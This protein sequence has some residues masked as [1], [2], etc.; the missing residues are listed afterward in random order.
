MKSHDRVLKCSFSDCD[1][2]H[3]CFSSQSLLDQHLSETH[4]NRDSVPTKSSH[5]EPYHPQDLRS[6]FLDAI[7]AEELICARKLLE[8]IPNPPL[9]KAM[10]NAIRTSSVPAVRLL[11]EFGYTD[12]IN[13]PDENL[14][15]VIQSKE[16]EILRVFLEHGANPKTF[17]GIP[18]YDADKNQGP[19]DLAFTAKSPES[20]K[21]LMNYGAD[22]KLRTWNLRGMHGWKEMGPEEELV[23]IQCIQILLEHT[24]SESAESELLLAISEGCK[25]IEI[26]RYLLENG[27][28]INFICVRKEVPYLKIGSTAIY[29][30]T[31][32]ANKRSAEFLRFLLQSGADP[33]IKSGK[34]AG[35]RP[36]ARNVSKYLG[37]TWDELCQSTSSSRRTINPAVT[38]GVPAQSN[39]A[40]RSADYDRPVSGD[41]P[42]RPL[43]PFSIDSGNQSQQERP[44]GQEESSTSKRRRLA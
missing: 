43:E 3:I 40:V 4:Q 21:L 41:L 22:I 17:P 34:L 29:L 19:V 12:Y 30:A 24:A 16:V 28:N 10:E 9:S 31:R 14:H 37:M 2:A 20:M 26:A 44:L 39:I 15:L 5:N 13:T 42:L 32:H 38:S 1:L 33:T 7:E 25:S 11:L 35:E 8:R 36:G 6:I 27:A 23:A 18:H